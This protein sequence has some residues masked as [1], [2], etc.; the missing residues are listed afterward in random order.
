MYARRPRS[1]L[2]S[3]A[4]SLV[5]GSLDPSAHSSSTSSLS[6]SPYLKQAEPFFIGSEPLALEWPSSGA[7]PLSLDLFSYVL[8]LDSCFRVHSEDSSI[9]LSLMNIVYVEVC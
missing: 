2:S 7:A 3:Q 1:Y 5:L 8:L 9:P 4:V 6:L